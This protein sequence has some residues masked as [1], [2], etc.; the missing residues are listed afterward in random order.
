MPC[1]SAPH[2]LGVCW[3]QYWTADKLDI[4]PVS[5]LVVSVAYGAP[6]SEHFGEHVREQFV[7]LL[8]GNYE[9]N[10]RTANTPPLGGVRVFAVRDTYSLDL[11]F[12]FAARG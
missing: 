10:K 4:W 11:M 8:V 7:F 9:A 1:P 12:S 2:P 5:G 3:A 6:W